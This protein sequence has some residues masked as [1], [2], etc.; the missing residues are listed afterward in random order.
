MAGRLKGFD[1][2]ARTHFRQPEWPVTAILGT[3]ATNWQR[4]SSEKTRASSLLLITLIRSSH[5]VSDYQPLFQLVGIQE[6]DGMILRP[7]QSAVTDFKTYVQRL[8]RMGANKM[9]HNC[10]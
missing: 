6:L 9:S 2:S 4:V 7:M 5:A 3:R 1:R 10:S 8:A